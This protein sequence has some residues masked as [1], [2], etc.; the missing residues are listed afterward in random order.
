[1]SLSSLVSV[2]VPE[3]SR[4]IIPPF[5]ME[6]S[7]D[8]RKIGSSSGSESFASTSITTEIFT[9]VEISRSSTATGF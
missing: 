1:M 6:L 2:D 9:G 5:T 4:V 8:S 7:K 3:S